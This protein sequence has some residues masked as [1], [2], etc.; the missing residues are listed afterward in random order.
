MNNRRERPPDGPGANG[1]R[2]GK[3][4]YSL[5]TANGNWIED[6]GGAS[7]YKRGFT[8]DKFETEGQHAQT[9]RSLTRDPEFGAG[10]P[11]KFIDPRTTNDV[12][13]PP[14]GGQ[15][16]QWETNTQT[17][18]K[19]TT[20]VRVLQSTNQLPKSNIAPVA[21]D[22]YRKAW[23]NDTVESRNMRFQTESRR[24]GNGGAPDR[25]KVPSVRYLPGTP[26]AF[27]RF[28]ERLV[29]RF[30]ILAMSSL[31]SAVANRAEI[32]SGDFYKLVHGIGIKMIRV[33]IEGVCV[34]LFFRV[35]IDSGRTSAL[36]PAMFNGFTDDF[37]CCRC[38]A[39]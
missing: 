16:G 9:G 19:N 20:G 34:M 8:S 35:F 14:A 25:F 22:N 15:E 36:F 10:L 1:L 38:L 30:G 24:A 2:G 4:C 7:C 27:E 29:E 39:T 28:R 26:I 13:N 3:N 17:M 33:E 12:F 5:K 31:R 23:T 6:Y 18:M 11:K 21:L 37:F 32:S